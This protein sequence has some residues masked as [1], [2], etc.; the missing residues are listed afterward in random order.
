MIISVREDVLDDDQ[1]LS[2]DPA[3]FEPEGPAG[4]II[5][6]KKQTALRDALATQSVKACLDQAATDAA[7]PM[8]NRDGEMM[9]IAAPSVV[10]TEHSPNELT[11]CVGRD[12]AE[13]RVSLQKGT[14]GLTGIGLIETDTLGGF[15]QRQRRI[16]I[17]KSESAE[18]VTGGCRA[19]R[20][21]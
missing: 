1:I 4:G 9:Q 10:P 20:I 5:R 2:R 21:G 3:V 15:P 13:F 14:D 8:G 19:R 16:V 6:V 18:G 11:L 12:E 17:T 7:P